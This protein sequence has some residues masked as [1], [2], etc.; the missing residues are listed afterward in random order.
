MNFFWFGEGAGRLKFRSRDP[1][2]WQAP[3]RAADGST[4]TS[5]A[6]PTAFKQ[7]NDGDLGNKYGVRGLIRRFVESFQSLWAD[8]AS[9]GGILRPQPRSKIG[10]GPRIASKGPR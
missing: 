1:S 6:D 8:K 3:A 9:A 7:H 2:P 10:D 4:T 5:Q